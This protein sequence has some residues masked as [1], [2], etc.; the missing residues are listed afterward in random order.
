MQKWEYCKVAKSLTGNFF[1][2][3][4]GAERLTLDV[5]TKIEMLNIMG[6]DGWDL[7]DPHKDESGFY[8][9]KRPLEEIA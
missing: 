9:F 3:I 7:I 6:K 5:D 2:D 1:I 8:F 4:P